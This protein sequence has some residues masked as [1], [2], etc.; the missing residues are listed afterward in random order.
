ML[1]FLS[2]LVSQAFQPLCCW[3]L[4]SRTAMLGISTFPSIFPSINLSEDKLIFAAHTHHT[5]HNFI[6]MNNLLRYQTIKNV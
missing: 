3:N 1:G 6:T 5:E 4:S 2:L